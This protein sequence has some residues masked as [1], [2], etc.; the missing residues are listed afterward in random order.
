MA[1]VPGLGSSALVSV[2][3]CDGNVPAVVACC[4]EDGNLRIVSYCSNVDGS[5][6]ESPWFPFFDC[7]MDPG[8]F[9]SGESLPRPACSGPY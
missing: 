8:N 3:D 7:R 2:A 5:Y 4:W 6:D 9:R 1:G